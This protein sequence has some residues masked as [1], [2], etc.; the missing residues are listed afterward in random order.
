MASRQ[1][2]RKKTAYE[3]K[4][5]PTS[6]SARVKMTLKVGDHYISVEGNEERSLPDQY[7]VRMDREW[8][9]LYEDVYTMCDEELGKIVDDI[10]KPIKSK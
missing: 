3:F 1:V 5:T 8:K 4:G 2:E 9:A 6:I 7:D 10:R